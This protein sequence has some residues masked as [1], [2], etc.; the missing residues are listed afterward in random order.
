MNTPIS[1]RHWNAKSTFT[2][3]NVGLQSVVLL[4]LFNFQWEQPWDHEAVKSQA[5][6]YTINKEEQSFQQTLVQHCIEKVK[7]ILNMECF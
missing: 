1:V 6:T 7:E 5:Q 2:V 3:E 4:A